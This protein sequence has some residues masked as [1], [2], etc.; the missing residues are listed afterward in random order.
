MGHTGVSHMNG[1]NI[2][3]LVISKQTVIRVCVFTKF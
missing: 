3:V 2:I 1:L